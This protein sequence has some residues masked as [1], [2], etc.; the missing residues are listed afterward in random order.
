MLKIPFAAWHVAAA[1]AWSVA[2]TAQEP[3]L[4][5]FSP[6]QGGF[7]QI[8]DGQGTIVRQWSGTGTL[9]VH[10]EE[11]GGIIRGMVEPNSGF[12]GTTGRLQRRDVLDNVTWDMVVSN[13]DR[14]MHH[15]IFTLPNGNV[16]VMVVD[17]LAR[18]DAIAAGRDP[19]KLTAP[20]WLPESILEI[21]QTGPTTGQVVWEWHV[22][23]HLVQDFDPLLPNF[24]NVADH[25]ELVDINYPPVVLS[26][27]GDWNHCN[28]IDYD[29]VNDWII[30][31]SREQDECWLI[32][33]STTTTEAAGHTGG[34]RGRGG[35]LLWRWGNP[36]CYGRG[37]AADRALF[38]QHDPRFI[39]QGFPGAG[40]ITIFNNQALPQQSTVIEIELPVDASGA[41]FVDPVSGVFGPAAPVWTYTAP[42][43]YSA[44]VS[45]A[46][47]LR[48]GNTLICSGAQSELLE[49]TSAGQTVWSHTDPGNTFTF[50]VDAIERRIWSDNDELS[51]A[52]GGSVTFTHQ[53][54]SVR[55]GNFY[56]LLGSLSGT[57]PGTP[58][59]GGAI[60]PLNTDGLLLGML[61]F[62]NFAVFIDTFGVVDSLGRARSAITVPPNL[63]VPALVG[64]E[65]SLC[66]IL[67][68]S[69]G[70]IAEI[71]NVET[72]RIAP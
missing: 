65:M 10:M 53:C 45:S 33:H 67:I 50:Q 28:G 35:D 62:P 14:L 12:P 59:P 58:L 38:R 32:D 63:L 69:V 17:W 5:L 68:D 66:H 54:D 52:S 18:A 21:E 6:T 42:G 43:F 41:P 34:A 30:I 20:G 8:V 13:P 57:S 31:S 1:I 46:Q 4:R 37:T 27:T 36:E 49:V 40:N 24:G 72:V 16:L 48:N 47:R 61:T 25:P 39:P 26:L 22:M 15:D 19:T 71:S 11:D 23:D 55:A 70:D 3:G 51:A 2:T 44:F 56:F 29:P 60:L 64:A 7:T 9:V